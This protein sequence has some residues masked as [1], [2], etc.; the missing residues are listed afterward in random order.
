FGGEISPACPGYT[1]PQPPDISNDLTEECLWAADP[2][3]TQNAGTGPDITQFCA[4]DTTIAADFGNPGPDQCLFTVTGGNGNIAALTFADS[5]APP[6]ATC[7]V[8]WIPKTTTANLAAMKEMP[9]ATPRTISIHTPVLATFR[10]FPFR[11][12]TST[13]PR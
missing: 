5:L 12:M 6:A 9:R 10:I 4:T 2:I 3:E 13:T 7:P 1:P 8:A 11:A